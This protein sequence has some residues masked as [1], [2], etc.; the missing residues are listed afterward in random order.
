MEITKRKHKEQRHE[1]A[2]KYYELNKDS[3]LERTKQWR[4]LN[5]E[6][7]RENNKKSEA[8][9]LIKLTCDVCGCETSQKNLSRHKQSKKCVAPMTET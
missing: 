6:K 2:K 7:V 1:Y 9:R 4:D 5:P 3:E 8:K